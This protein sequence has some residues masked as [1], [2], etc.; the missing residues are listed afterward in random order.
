MRTLVVDLHALLRGFCWAR[1]AVAF[2]LMG[3]GPWAPAVL[4]PTAAGGLVFAVF[5]LVVGSSAVLLLAGPP[6]RPRVVAWLL[7]LLDAALVTAVVAA[8]GGARSV[9]VFLY[10]LLAT[11]A[12]LLLSRSGALTIALISSGLYAILIL[13][14]AIVPALAFGDPVDHTAP[15]DVLTI[16]VTSGT[17]TVV[18]M[19]ASG[20][21]EHSLLSQRDLA[22]E[23]R[24]LGDLRAFSE[25]I[26]QS[27]GTGLVALD[28]A[29][30]ITTLNRAAETMTGVPASRAVGAPWAEVFGPG[31]TPADIEAATAGASIRREIEVSRPD[32]ATVPMRITASPLEAGDGTRLG[33]I[34][35][36]EDLSSVRAMEA[37]IRQ[38]DRLAT[39]GR[40]AANI[41]H[42][43]RNPL[44]S[45]SGAVEALTGADG[46]PETRARLTEIVV[47]ESGRLSVIIDNV[48]TYTRPA[49]LVLERLDAAAVLDDVL[50]ALAARAPGDG[51]KIVRA[52][53]PTLPLEADR[54][55]LRQV[56]WTLCV[57]AVGAMPT[58]GELRVEGQRRGGVVEVTVS[59]TGEGIPP[60][61]LAHAFEPFF[62]VRPD[63]T[64]LGYAL[65]HRIVREHGG[66]VTARSEGGL[67]AEFTVRFPE[68]HG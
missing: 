56:V 41:A 20:L 64:G 3:V 14:R 17:L 27:A 62:A 68:W 36:C 39:L 25:A 23:R 37:E 66:E 43:I 31:L 19:V 13:A 67:G 7:C 9:L 26:F 57:N 24:S 10:V 32:G 55:G 38:A 34:A 48:L 15:L 58:G 51:V 11:A 65:V 63:A 60:Q 35:A 18:S 12:C 52:F 44:A 2:F 33:C 28:R 22:T 1:L 21:A 49:P 47:R 46:P 45:L 50:R 40:M 59:D 6:P 4:L 61:S 29:H 54:Q 8:T 53:P 5:A 30:R 16:F 42:E